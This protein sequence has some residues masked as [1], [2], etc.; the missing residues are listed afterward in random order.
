MP[1]LPNVLA[2]LSFLTTTPAIIGLAIT[3]SVIVIISEKLS[4]DIF[5][6]EDINLLETIANQSA[7]AMRNARLMMSWN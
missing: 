3:A 5:T 1:T 6:K 4:G 2:R 7:I